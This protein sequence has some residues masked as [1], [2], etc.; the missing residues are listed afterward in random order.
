MRIDWHWV[1]IDR[2]FYLVCRLGGRDVTG[3]FSS[4]AVLRRSVRSVRSQELLRGSQAKGML[5]TLEF[6]GE[7]CFFYSLTGVYVCVCVYVYVC[8]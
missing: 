1:S 7:V 4:V 8:R 3:G 2:S 5:S 6:D